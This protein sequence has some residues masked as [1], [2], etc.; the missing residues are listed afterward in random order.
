MAKLV[1]YHRITS[2]DGVCDDASSTV[3][4]DIIDTKAPNKVVNVTDV[5]LVGLGGE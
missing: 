5:L 4:W 2:W 3:E 1:E